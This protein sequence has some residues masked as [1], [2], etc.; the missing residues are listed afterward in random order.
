MTLHSRQ[1]IER[2]ARNSV[3][4]RGEAR[5]GHVQRAD[6]AWCGQRT[7]ATRGLC[8]RPVRTDAPA[9]LCGI[10]TSQV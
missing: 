6:G 1:V 4:G 10:R 8:L 9:V 2:Q 3:A 7:C 5:R